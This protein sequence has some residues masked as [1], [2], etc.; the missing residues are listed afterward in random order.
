MGLL[1]AVALG[2]IKVD[3]ISILLTFFLSSFLDFD[4]KR[5]RVLSR[6]TWY[7]HASKSSSE[8]NSALINV[9]C[10]HKN[11]RLCSLCMK[12]LFSSI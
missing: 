5:R 10:M 4:K 9:I 11:V 2:S 6:I 12:M 3:N 8:K 7:T 1:G